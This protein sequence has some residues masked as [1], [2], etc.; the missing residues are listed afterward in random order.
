MES[1]GHYERNWTEEEKIKVNLYFLYFLLEIQ[2]IYLLNNDNILKIF[3]IGKFLKY[4]HHV[5]LK[6]AEMVWSAET[7]FNQFFFKIIFFQ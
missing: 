4:D 2:T 7:F 6:I 3:Q 5:P 1:F